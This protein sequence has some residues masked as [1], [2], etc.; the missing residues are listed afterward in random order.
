MKQIHV[1]GTSNLGSIGSGRN[2]R[3]E[4][5]HSDQTQKQLISECISQVSQKRRLASLHAMVA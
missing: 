5:Y 1:S 3:L 4:I 2:T